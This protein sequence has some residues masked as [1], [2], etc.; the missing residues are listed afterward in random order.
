MIGVTGALGREYES[1]EKNTAEQ[2]SKPDLGDLQEKT[3]V[4]C[5]TNDYA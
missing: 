1:G 3:L 2:D 5:L 4:S